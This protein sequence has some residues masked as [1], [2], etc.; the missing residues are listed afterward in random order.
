MKRPPVWLTYTLLRLVYF[1]VPF[2]LLYGSGVW[3]WLSLLIAVFF[4]SALSMLT[5][6]KLRAELAASIDRARRQPTT[7]TAVDEAFEDKADR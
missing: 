4:A 1:T 6:H 7:P 3:W 2:A 5:L